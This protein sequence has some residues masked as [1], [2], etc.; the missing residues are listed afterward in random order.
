MAF[1]T[2]AQ[3]ALNVP[4]PVN[5]TLAHNGYQ[6]A[7]ALPLGTSAQIDLSFQGS[8]G[9]RIPTAAEL[10][11]APLARQFVYAGANANLNGTPAPGSGANWAFTA[12]MQ[13]F[14]ANAVPYFNTTFFHADF[15]NGPGAGCGLNEYP[16]NSGN[17][18]EFLVVR[19]M[20]AVSEPATWAM[21][22][23]GVMTI[24]GALRATRR[25]RAVTVSY[26]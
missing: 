26:A 24:G 16:W 23:L 4:V 21:M 1:A 22:L 20:G 25:T 11:L 12:G 13:G 6:W 8:L 17:V 5:A 10:L 14:A 7:W 9:W 3:A 19:G 15:C 18:A 2:S